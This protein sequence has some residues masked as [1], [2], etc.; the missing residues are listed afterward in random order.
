MKRWIHWFLV[1]A[2]CMPLLIGLLIASAPVPPQAKA[3]RQA[4]PRPIIIA[5]LGSAL[6]SSL[7]MEQFARN[8]P[9]VFLEN[10]LRRYE[11]DVRGYHA[12]MQKQERIQGRLQSKEIIDVWFR[13][14]P[15]AVLMR[16]IDGARKAD[17]ALYVEGE[18]HDK[19]LARPN[20]ALARRLVGD[21]VERDVDGMDARAS[22]RYPLS[23]F[24]M[25]K[26]TE[27]TLAA[28]QIA[29]EQGKLH[30]E[31]L[32]MQKVK[33]AGDRLCFKLRRTYEAPE[34]D[35]VVELT[36]FVDQDN[37]LQVGSI[38]KGV[39]NKLIGE[40]FFRDIQ[41]NPIYPETV[42]TRTALVEVATGALR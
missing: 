40:Y 4:E 26:A 1:L 37:W 23:Q 39:Q 5:D 14:K 6:P 41:L 35:G 17:R 9:T 18:N 28:W 33:E 10:C 25:R 38:L 19:M 24:G 34:N 12:T 16:W 27:R 8:E 7:A 3:K 31:F 11:R 29:K 42:F 32:G 2:V 20:G 13:D 15:H 22:G 21:I 30:V 36:I